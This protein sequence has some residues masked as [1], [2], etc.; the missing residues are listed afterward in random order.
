MAQGDRRSAASGGCSE[1]CFEEGSQT[2][3]TQ[4]PLFGLIRRC[5]PSCVSRA[6]PPLPLRKIYH[7]IDS[8]KRG[9][10]RFSPYRV[11]CIDWIEGN[12]LRY[13]V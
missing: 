7:F 2:A 4:Y 5:I 3:D 13:I 12:S 1:G 9:L 8:L 6:H 10:P 11:L